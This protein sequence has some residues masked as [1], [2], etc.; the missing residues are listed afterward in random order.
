MDL[1]RSYPLIDVPICTFLVESV[2]LYHRSEEGMEIK[3]KHLPF[4][5]ES[6]NVY[7]KSEEGNR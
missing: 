3:G 5:A 1:Q 2:N 7:H 4:V 6:V